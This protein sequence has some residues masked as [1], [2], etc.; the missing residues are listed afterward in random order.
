MKPAAPGAASTTSEG[1]KSKGE[2]NEQILMLFPIGAGKWAFQ[3]SPKPM[4]TATMLAST[5]AAAA[6]ARLEPV[7]LPGFACK[8]K[9]GNHMP[10]GIHFVIK[11]MLACQPPPS[12]GGG[13]LGA[14]GSFLS[15]LV[16]C[17]DMLAIMAGLL[18]GHVINRMM[19]S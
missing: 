14:I 7:Q 6:A 12:D 16:T 8:P 4:P 5:A 1:D 11:P 9:E 15:Q 13:V 2:D 17:G 18:L 3:I 10:L 19:H